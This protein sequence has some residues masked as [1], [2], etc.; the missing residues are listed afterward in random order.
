[1]TVQHHGKDPAPF[2]RKTDPNREFAR[3]DHS[4]SAMCWNAADFHYHLCNLCDDIA[5]N[6]V[7]EPQEVV[8]RLDRVC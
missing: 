6:L 4:R 8:P 1:M 5:R 3:L 2:A 7:V